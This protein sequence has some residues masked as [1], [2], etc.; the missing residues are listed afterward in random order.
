MS[1]LETA[2]ISQDEDFVVEGDLDYILWNLISLYVST[3]IKIA[4]AWSW[5]SE[6]VQRQLFTDQSLKKIEEREEEDLKVARKERRN[7]NL[8]M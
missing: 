8:R 1:G 5:A 2:R 6:N 7:L 3:E 4:E